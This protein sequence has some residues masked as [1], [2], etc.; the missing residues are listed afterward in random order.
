MPPFLRYPSQPPSTSGST[1]NRLFEEH[2][3]LTPP[4]HRRETSLRLPRT[5]YPTCAELHFTLCLAKNN[6]KHHP[7]KRKRDYR[8]TAVSKNNTMTLRLWPRKYMFRSCRNFEAQQQF[9]QTTKKTIPNRTTQI[10][11]T[12]IRRAINHRNSFFS[13]SPQHNNL[14]NA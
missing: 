9:Q 10:N 1:L 12:H 6:T 14:I 3:H 7:T 4:A 13:S 8:P 5:P 2:N 11:R